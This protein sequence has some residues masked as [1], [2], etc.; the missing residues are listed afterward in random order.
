MYAL[1]GQG[2]GIRCSG[3]E[4]LPRVIMPAASDARQARSCMAASLE[5][6]NGL[7]CWHLM[8][9]VQWV[10]RPVTRD[11]DHVS[12]S[13][14][15]ICTSAACWDTA[16]FRMALSS[17]KASLRRS[18]LL[19]PEA[20]GPGTI[21]VEREGRQWCTSDL[22]VQEVGGGRILDRWGP[23]LC[24]CVL[25]CHVADPSRLCQSPLRCRCHV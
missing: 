18:V 11:Q 16:T 13:R 7:V 19:A 3:C 10:S 20:A 5:S 17:Y 8:L 2:L 15:S 21:G 23:V 1:R 4:G 25:V 12:C 14:C 24:M 6:L 9:L 22:F